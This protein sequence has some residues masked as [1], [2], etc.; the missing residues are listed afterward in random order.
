MDN[1]Y[2]LDEALDY[3]NESNFTEKIKESISSLIRKIKQGIINLISKI[4]N[5]L[6]KCK[7]S[8]IKSSINNILTK[9]KAALG[10]IESIEK[11]DE[12][13]QEQQRNAINKLAEEIKSLTIT[14]KIV[15]HPETFCDTIHLGDIKNYVKPKLD[16]N[17]N[18][19]SFAGYE[20]DVIDEYQ[21]RSKLDIIK[22]H[23]PDDHVISC[24]IVDKENFE[25]IS[26]HKWGYDEID[27]KLKSLLDSKGGCI[28]IEQ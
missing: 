20:K 6:E 18:Y 25:F 11:L 15:S 24:M 10:D 21:K 5:F 23:K 12:Q 9:V 28:L 17:K 8:K 16:D 4:Q 14:F 7:D 1:L 13:K 2:T 19:I 26:Y 3:L 22:N 27:D